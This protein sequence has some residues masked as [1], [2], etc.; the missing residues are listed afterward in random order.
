MHKLYFT[1]VAAIM[2]DET[3]NGTAAIMADG[4]HNGAAAIMA[5]GTHNNLKEGSVEVS[6]FPLHICLYNASLLCVSQIGMRRYK[7]RL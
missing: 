4:T 7:Q 2:A 5:D 6:F 3:H 1:V